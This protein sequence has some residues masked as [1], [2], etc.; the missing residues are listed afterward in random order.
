[1]MQLSFVF[2]VKVSFQMKGLRLRS[3]LC[4]ALT[5]DTSG[6]MLQISMVFAVQVAL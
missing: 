2:A 1:M 3:L 6:S 4:E 5:A